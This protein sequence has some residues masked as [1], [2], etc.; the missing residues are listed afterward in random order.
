MSMSRRTFFVLI[1]SRTKILNV[2]VVEHCIN[3]HSKLTSII[4]KIF[5]KKKVSL[6]KLKTKK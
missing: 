6:K 3:Y 5:S 2:I 1:K 4:K